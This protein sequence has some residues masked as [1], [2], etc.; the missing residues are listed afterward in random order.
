MDVLRRRL[1]LRAAVV[2][3][4]LSIISVDAFH[5][6]K[7]EIPPPTDAPQPLAPDESVKRF[8]VPSGFRLELIAAEPLVREPAGMCWD[9][10]GRLFVCELH[11]YNMD[12]QL[13]IDELNKAGKLDHEVRRVRASDAIKEA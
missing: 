5:A 1:L 3:A 6:T 8:H 10:R 13:D 4:F 11:G 7:A 2:A 12:G 9:A